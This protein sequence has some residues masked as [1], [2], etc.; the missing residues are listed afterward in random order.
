MSSTDDP[1]LED[2]TDEE[3]LGEPIA[4]LENFEE[5]VSPALI[6]RVLSS[7]RRRRFAGHVLMFT[8]S[9]FGAVAVEFLTMVH[10]LFE[11]N[12]A[13]RGDGD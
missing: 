12:K 10:S 7:V 6:D 4:E 11:P 9:A 8:W 5:A 13:D 3:D 2:P 1:S